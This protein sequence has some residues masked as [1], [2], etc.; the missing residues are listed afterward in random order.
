[1]SNELP[2]DDHMQNRISKL[3]SGE[4]L[5]S[6]AGMNEVE[7]MKARISELEAQLSKREAQENKKVEERTAPRKTQAANA[8]IVEP[9]ISLISRT[10]VSGR[11]PWF[12]RIWD[13]LTKASD[14][15]TD[16]S[17][18]NSAR[19]AASFLFIIS[20]LTFMGAL[21]RIPRLGIFGAFSGMLGY[22]LFATLFAYGFTRTK[23]Y[24][25]GIFVFS[26][27]FGSLAYIS[28]VLEGKQADISVLILLYIPLSL[29]VASAFLSSWAVFLLTGLNV[30]AF[31][32]TTRFGIQYVP[33]NFGAQ[34]GII[35]TIGMVLIALTNFTKQS[36]KNET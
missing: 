24:R 25:A 18:R 21:A 34:S 3:Y 6:Y 26:M 17:E 35:T 4:N 7:A 10:S 23:Y 31:F 28:M 27:L 2:L 8:K 15:L 30:G 5:P 12:V 20:F 11:F 36:E 16:I 22:A 13:W 33:A 14:G 32:L 29:I 1:M 9:T 19:L